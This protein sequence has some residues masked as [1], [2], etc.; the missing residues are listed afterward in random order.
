MTARLGF[1]EL[2]LTLLV[3]YRRKFYKPTK[4]PWGYRL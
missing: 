2:V 4:L 3:N 1:K